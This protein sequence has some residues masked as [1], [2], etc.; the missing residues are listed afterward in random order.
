MKMTKNYVQTESGSSFQ[1]SHEKSGEK[2]GNLILEVE[3]E[4]W[5]SAVLD[6]V[7]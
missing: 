1:H 2:S 5:L 4:P 6:C 7:L 3:W